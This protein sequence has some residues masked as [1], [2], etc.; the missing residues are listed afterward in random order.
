MGV[1]VQMKN[2]LRDKKMTI[3]QLS[4]K[5]G[6]SVNTLYSITKRDSERV[7]RVVLQRI[8]DVLEVHILDLLG[9]ADEL[10]SYN[11][12][13]TLSPDT[14]ESRVLANFLNTSGVRNIYDSLTEEEKE[15]LLVKSNLTKPGEP[16]GEVEHPQE[17]SSPESVIVEQIKSV[18]GETV[19]DTFSM[20]V[21]LD[22]GDQGEIRGEVKQML[23]QG[24]YLMQEG[25]LA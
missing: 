18:Y 24:K 12:Q 25:N 23:K 7:D 3:K 15:D 9:V 6:I 21:Q 13:F 14:P 22:A 2:I 20:Y 17:K 10:D 8:A 19:S 5:S 1:G 4:E 16:L 11:V